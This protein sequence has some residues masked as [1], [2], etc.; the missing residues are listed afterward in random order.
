M[1][2][3]AV[4]PA[5]SGSDRSKQNEATGFVARS[6]RTRHTK[7]HGASAMSDERCDLPRQETQLVYAVGEGGAPQYTPSHA[8]RHAK[9]VRFAWHRSAPRRQKLDPVAWIYRSATHCPAEPSLGSFA[10]AH[11]EINLILG[12][13]RATGSLLRSVCAASST[14]PRQMWTNA[15]SRAITLVETTIKDRPAFMS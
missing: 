4:L 6:T 9:R 2:R 1:L 5:K 12:R 14:D 11:S 10:V 8:W 15:H 7:P 13:L 3:P